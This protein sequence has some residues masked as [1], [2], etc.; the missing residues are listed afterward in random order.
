MH[1][2]KTEHALTI[3]QACFAS[4]GNTSLNKD[5]I[6]HNLLAFAV[7]ERHIKKHTKIKNIMVEKHDGLRM[8]GAALYSLVYQPLQK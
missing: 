6:K 3:K 4:P 8:Y 2:L 7:D 1:Y 5:Y